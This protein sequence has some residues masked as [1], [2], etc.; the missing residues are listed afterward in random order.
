M[1]L[2]SRGSGSL[3]LSQKTSGSNPLRVIFIEKHFD[4]TSFS[5]VGGRRLI[6]QTAEYCGIEQS[7]SSSAS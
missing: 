4:N 7:G 5:P 1:A 2:S 6:K 3:V